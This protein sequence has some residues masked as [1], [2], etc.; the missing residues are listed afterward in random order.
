MPKELINHLTKIADMYLDEEERHY[1]EAVL[2]AK[3]HNKDET[4]LKDHIFHSLLVISHW[5]KENH[6]MKDEPYLITDC[7][8]TDILYQQH[9][10]NFSQ[11]DFCANCLKPFE[12]IIETEYKEEE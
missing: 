7:C 4:D 3:M 9:K 2:T 10:D 1:D 12:A 6:T 11:W 5:I 8:G